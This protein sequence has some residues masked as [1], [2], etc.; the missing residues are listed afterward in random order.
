MNE[1][2]SFVTAIVLVIEIAAAAVIAVLNV[3][4]VRF[5]E[6]RVRPRLDAN[7][8]LPLFDALSARARS[9]TAIGIYLLVL[10]GIGAAGI[11][12]TTIF[13]PLRAINGALLLYLIAGPRIYGTALRQRARSQHSE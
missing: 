1:A 8:E 10:T 3:T 13:P 5:L 2:L 9:I 4:E 7:E 11:S 6:R 12:L